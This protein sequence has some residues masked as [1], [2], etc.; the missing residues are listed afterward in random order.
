MRACPRL[1]LI[2]GTFDPIHRGHLAAADAAQRAL[3]LETIR[4]IPSAQPPHRPESPRATSAQR[5]EMVRC[6]VAGTS[7]WE[8]SDIELRRGGTSYTSQT[9]AALQREGMSPS[10]MFFIIGADAFAEIET[11]HDYPAVLD[12]AHYAVVARPGTTLASLSARVPGLSNRL[13]EAEEVV[14][15]A[16]PRIVLIAAETP[17]VSSTD[18]RRRIARGESVAGLVSDAVAAYIAQHNLYKGAK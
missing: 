6:A 18:I 12:A 5:L 8:A 16:T 2:G 15:A 11:W 9:L 1:G 4:F 7:T 3:S 13:I 10:L 17:D 14:K